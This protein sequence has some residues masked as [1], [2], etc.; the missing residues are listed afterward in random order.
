MSDPKKTNAGKLQ[1]FHDSFSAKIT[2]YIIKITDYIT[3][4][5]QR[6]ANK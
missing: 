5:P 2:D 1:N 4:V 3:E 6:S